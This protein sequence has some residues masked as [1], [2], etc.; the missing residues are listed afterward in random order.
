MAI[1]AEFIMPL[2]MPIK[3]YKDMTK[4]RGIMRSALRLAQC[5]N[6]ATMGWPICTGCRRIITKA[7]STSI[8]VYPLIKS[9]N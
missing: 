5:M 8:K 4:Q 1:M 2:G 7:S 9:H 3:S 6:V